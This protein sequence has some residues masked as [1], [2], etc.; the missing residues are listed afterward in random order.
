MIENCSAAG[1]AGDG[2]RCMGCFDSNST[3]QMSPRSMHPDGVNA[4]MADGSVRFI[5]DTIESVATQNGC[6]DYRRAP[7]QALHTR[8]GGEVVQTF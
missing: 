7:W 1:L 5:S 2:S 3:A 8:S 6:G 4:M